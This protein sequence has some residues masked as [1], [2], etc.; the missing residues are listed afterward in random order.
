MRSRQ[1]T[2]GISRRAL[3]VILWLSQLNY[4]NGGIRQL[5]S[6]VGEKLK[7]RRQSLSLTQ[8]QVADKLGF[9]R[10]NYCEKLGSWQI[11]SKALSTTNESFV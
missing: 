5:M 7:Q 6:S 9:T 3:A 4:T 11:C 8:Q 1:R 10:C 2:G